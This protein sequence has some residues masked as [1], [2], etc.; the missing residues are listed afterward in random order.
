MERD[1]D[2]DKLARTALCDLL[3]PYAARTGASASEPPE[4]GS[5]AACEQAWVQTWA[6]PEHVSAAALEASRS[7][8]A[9][10]VP[11]RVQKFIRES[12]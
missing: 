2:V 12:L 11:E 10:D 7:V 1:L 6:L 5:F 3:E 8:W 4:P 9:G